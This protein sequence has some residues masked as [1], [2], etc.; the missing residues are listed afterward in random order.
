MSQ[1][2]LKSRAHVYFARNTE[3][4]RVK[5]GSSWVP[6]SRVRSLSRTEHAPVELLAVIR[7]AGPIVEREMH[8]RFEHLRWRGEW[9]E[10]MPELLGYIAEVA[11]G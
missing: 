5:I 3:S 9:Y 10:P 4:G 2:S 8:E 11:R 7:D 1:P 6:A